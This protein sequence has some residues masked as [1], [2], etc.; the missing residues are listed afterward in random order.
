[1]D[2]KKLKLT[3]KLFLLTGLINLV[4]VSVVKGFL[5]NPEVGH[6]F[7]GFN[8]ELYISDIYLYIGFVWLL[9]ALIYLIDDYFNKEY[10]S[11]KIKKIHFYCT[12]PMIIILIITP[13]LDTYY[14][15]SEANGL[16]YSIFTMVSI[17]SMFGIIIGLGAF[18]INIINGLLKVVGL[19]KK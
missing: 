16:F 1:M 4:F 8:K 13:I 15:T 18:L 6:Q 5:N 9:F 7:K 17:F 11:E 3:S 19:I 12:L 2:L 10:L 14:P